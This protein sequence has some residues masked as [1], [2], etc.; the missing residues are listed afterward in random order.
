MLKKLLLCTALS[1]LAF[2][3]TETGNLKHEISLQSEASQ[4]ELAE[5]V[6]NQTPQELQADVLKKRLKI[7]AAIATIGV[8]VVG[9]TI[10]SLILKKT[11]NQALLTKENNIRAEITGLIYNIA[12][13]TREDAIPAMEK[14]L[15]KY[16]FNII[17]NELD[18][19]NQT[20]EKIRMINRLKD[21][22]L[23]QVLMTEPFIEW[24]LQE[25]YRDITAIKNTPEDKIFSLTSAATFEDKKNGVEE[26]KT[27]IINLP[28][29]AKNK[30]KGQQY[31]AQLPQDFGQKITSYW[32]DDQ[33]LAKIFAD[34]APRLVEE[35]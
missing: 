22:G 25:L 6:E 27:F 28:K 15:L 13:A 18:R 12:L 4:P 8:V 17:K 20:T 34:T 26:I 14:K 31:R 30:I 19:F 29:E 32:K 21:I 9:G 7:I 1:T 24:T 16:D 33:E 23:K 11:I 2:F 10:A 5:T 35:T 3:S